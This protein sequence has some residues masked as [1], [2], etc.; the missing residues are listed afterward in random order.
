VGVIDAVTAGLNA[1]VLIEDVMGVSYEE[2]VSNIVNSHDQHNVTIVPDNSTAGKEPVVEL[3]L[4][5]LDVPSFA[6]AKRVYWRGSTGSLPYGGTETDLPVFPQHTVLLE[7]FCKRFEPASQLLQIDVT[8]ASGSIIYGTV[9]LAAGA[10]EGRGY[11]GKEI[12]FQIP[13]SVL[14]L[15]FTGTPEIVKGVVGIDYL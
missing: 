11:I 10:M 3:R 1:S 12:G 7:V 4:A 6:Y 14:K 13:S 5:N 2:D 8:D 15:K 9:T